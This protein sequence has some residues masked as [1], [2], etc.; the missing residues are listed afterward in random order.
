LI[1][2]ET[3][4]RLVEEAEEFAV[5]IRRDLHRWPELGNEEYKTTERIKQ[6]L[7]NLG[8]ETEQTLETGLIGIIKGKQ[9]YYKNN[10]ML[11][12]QGKKV[13]A[14]RADIDALPMQEEVCLPFSSERKGC[15][16]ACG[17][18][19]HT[20][21][22][23][24][25]AKVLNELKDLINGTVKLI[26]Q[27]AEE[28]SGGA[29]RMIEKGCLENPK[30]DYILGLH[31]KPDLP[32][33]TIGIRYGKVHASSDTFKITVKGTKSHGAY[34]ELGTDAIVAASQIVTNSQSI[35]S[36]NISPLNS[37]VITFGTVHGGNAVNI[38]ADSVVLEGTLRALDTSSREFL[39]KRLKAVVRLTAK[40]CGANAE[41]EF[42]KGYCALVNDNMV[43]DVINEVAFYDTTVEKIY[44]LKEPT[45]GV[46]DFAFFLE[47]VPGAFF[48]LGSGYKGRENQGIHT[49]EFE[50]DEKC[51]KIGIQVQ[52][53]SVL[54]LLNS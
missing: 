43:V 46:E 19:V 20:A 26:F 24:G 13:I 9:E 30:V 50:V 40:A 37:A 11:E 23:L 39:K 8:I 4:N 33:G 48:F 36:R 15:M 10:K 7:A 25:T 18:D 44:E 51:I 1:N 41:I 49:S 53:L 29:E 54:K 38:I 47:N 52:V 21:V 22:L 14:I 27:P 28:S 42:I 35:V 16:H 12:K 32:A 6:E 45:M 3:I 17:H 2:I 31:V 5:V 34:P